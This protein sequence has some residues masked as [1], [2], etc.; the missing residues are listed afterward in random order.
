MIISL[1]E[2]AVSSKEPEAGDPHPPAPAKSNKQRAPKPP[3][4]QPPAPPA[5]IATPASISVSPNTAPSVS[6]SSSGGWERSQ[7]TL[8]SVGN[9]VDRTFSSNMMSVP[10]STSTSVDKE[11]E[12][13]GPKSSPT[14]SQVRVC[15][16]R[17]T[18]QNPKSCFD[19][20][21]SGMQP[22]FMSPALFGPNPHNN[23][24][25]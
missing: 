6:E 5:V 7:S 11:K 8:P 10:S 21:V 19:V 13:E 1:Q 4:P 24:G 23:K 18:K 14:F 12:Q 3:T 17:H 16:G 25:F 2:I 9:A 15:F 22:A 20:R